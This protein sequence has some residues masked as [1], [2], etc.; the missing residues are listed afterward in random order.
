MKI[1][2]CHFQLEDCHGYFL[3]EGCNLRGSD[4]AT[5]AHVTPFCAGVDCYRLTHGHLEPLG[6]EVNPKRGKDWTECT[7][8]QVAKV[9]YELPI[10]VGLLLL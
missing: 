2:V 6:L 4:K 9:Q 5:L 8:F 7:V 1:F 10:L 3:E